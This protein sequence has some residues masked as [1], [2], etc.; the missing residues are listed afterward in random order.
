MNDMR[1]F[2]ASQQAYCVAAAS[3]LHLTAKGREIQKDSS[4]GGGFWRENIPRLRQISIVCSKEKLKQAG[5]QK[6]A[7]F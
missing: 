2:V 6:I 3:L 7:W 5:M 4:Y 1:C